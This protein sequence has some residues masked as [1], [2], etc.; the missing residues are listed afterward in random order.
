MAAKILP[1]K[2][3]PLKLAWRLFI[4]IQFC[5]ALLAAQQSSYYTVPGPNGIQFIQRLSW[6][7]DENA[8]LY[9][10]IIEQREKR[11]SRKEEYIQVRRF[12]TKES[13]VEFSLPPGNYRYR[14]LVYNLLR[15]GEYTSPWVDFEILAALQPE[16]S[17]F[18]PRSFDPNQGG[19]IKLVLEGR[20]LL[21]ESKIR[22]ERLGKSFPPRTYSPD[23]SGERAVVI[24]NAED[25][26]RG[27]YTIRVI[28]PGSLEASRQGFLVD[29][30]SSFR[31][32]AAY[33]PVIPSRGFVFEAFDKPLYPL[34]IGVRAAW[35]PLKGFW[36]TLGAEAVFGWGYL[37]DRKN[38]ADISAH[39]GE[40]GINALYQWNLNHFL[41]VNVRAGGG[42]NGILNL[43]FDHGIAQSDSYN[44]LSPMI[45][46]GLSLE[47]I[48]YRS[49]YAEAGVEGFVAFSKDTPQLFYL[50]PFAGVG[51]RF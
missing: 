42:L 21:P 49:L 17:G 9:E 24:Y 43:V 18:S 15:Q 50:K 46:M 4:L 13:S 32:L 29:A 44:A 47:W 1:A 45:D 10:L 37:N 11:D 35:L 34:G 27:S 36:G 19:E 48:C 5:P 16:L 38:N 3:F 12:V 39:F 25:L 28:N 6:L 26:S 22:L 23:P 33:A 2:R 40:L 14:V 51:W 20:N 41:A 7:E 8:S 31:V 30:P